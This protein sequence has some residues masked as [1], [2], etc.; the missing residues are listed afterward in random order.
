MNKRLLR[1]GAALAVGLAVVV[2]PGAQTSK[3][4]KASEVPQ[5]ARRDHGGA[6]P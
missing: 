1:G 2:G 5:R 4:I 3:P 6:R